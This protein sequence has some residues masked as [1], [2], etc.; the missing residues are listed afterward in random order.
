MVLAAVLGGSYLTFTTLQTQRDTTG[1]RGEAQATVLAR[2]LAESGQAIALTSITQLDGFENLGVFKSDRGYNGGVIAFENYDDT[3]TP[4]SPHGERVAIQVAGTYGTAT[5]RLH[6]VYEFHPMDFPGPIWLDVPYATATVAAAAMISGGGF[7]YE[8]QIDPRKATELDIAGL[9][10]SLD[11]ITSAMAAAGAAVGDWATTGKQ[12]LGDLGD[13]I[14]SA[15]D[16]YWEVK[17][18]V[19]TEDGDVVY[20]RAVTVSGSPTWGAP[21]AITRVVG[22]LT[23][24]NGA[25][26]T[27]SGALL[28]EG[29]LRV[30]GQM[31]WSGL[32]IVRTTKQS[33]AVDLTGQ[34]TITGALVVSQEAFPPGGHMDLTV[35]REPSGTWSTSFGRRAAGPGSLRATL[36]PQTQAW[37]WPFWN[38]IHR[39]DHPS[40]GDDAFADREQRIV[41]FVDADARD[42]QE[43]AYT[44][45]R[46]FLDYIGST[47]VQIEFANVTGA[48]GHAI[49]E[50][51][52]RGEDEIERSVALGFD[53]TE[54]AG[55]QKYRSMTFPA[56][57]LERLVIRPQSLRALK[58]LWDSNGVCPGAAM[59]TWP[60]CVGTDRTGRQGALTVRIRKPG[61]G[62]ILYEG[63]LYWHMQA[64]TEHD[65]YLSTLAAWQAAVASGTSPFGT[66]LTL[67]AN[68]NITYALGPIAA[69][70]DKV[71]FAGNRILHISTESDVGA[72]SGT[73]ADRPGNRY[74]QSGAGPGANGNGAGNQTNGATGGPGNGGR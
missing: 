57:D 42:P 69:L 67:A 15:D 16:L 73:A 19:D 46:E 49:A 52:I 48:H 6:S 29:S 43:R 11:D 26:L 35:L 53:D 2:Q 27:G 14:Q 20:D 47:P 62:D 31:A 25:Q 4:S 64:G 18:A 21:A 61:D 71:G 74:G 56:R 33:V 5:H 22:D 58:K 30:L 63:A 44:G 28:V 37:P 50:V 8:P 13:G 65:E 32:V 39:F 34:T 66:Q 51:A 45:L 72:T 10:L 70:A 24:P 54:L 23:V 55:P 40:T 38:H 12:R 9:G 68:A 3:L 1:R 36:W 41:R 60:I 59:P 17:S 7:G